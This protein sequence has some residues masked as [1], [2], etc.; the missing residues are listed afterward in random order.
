MVSRLGVL[1][2]TDYATEATT[3]I[4]ASDRCLAP[5]NMPPKMSDEQLIETPPSLS[6][7]Y[8]SVAHTSAVLPGAQCW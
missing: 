7:R 4:Y 1:A 8:V 3:K 6:A 2:I 5:A